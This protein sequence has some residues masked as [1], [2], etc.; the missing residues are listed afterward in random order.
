M[1]TSTMTYNRCT[2]PLGGVSLLSPQGGG[3]A[4]S[5]PLPDPPLGRGEKATR[6]HGAQVYGTVLRGPP[7]QACAPC[8]RWPG[9]QSHRRAAGPAPADRQQVAKTLLHASL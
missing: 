3:D 2:W 5:Q 7:R 1:F 8:R 9:K 6:D 4:P